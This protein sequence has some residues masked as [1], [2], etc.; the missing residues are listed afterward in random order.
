MKT[1]DIIRAW[2]DPLYT[3][4]LTGKQK[5]AVPSNPAGLIELDDMSLDMAA[6]NGTQ[7][8]QTRGC[9]NG[10]TA[11]TCATKG[12]GCNPIPATKAVDCTFSA[13]VD[14]LNQK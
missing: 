7:R 6:G 8:L 1:V 2:K 9:C 5:E 3:E 10:L 4:T 14:P 12:C 11:K 13:S